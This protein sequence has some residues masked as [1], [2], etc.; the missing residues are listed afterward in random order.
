MAQFTALQAQ[1]DALKYNTSNFASSL[2]GKQLTIN[3]GA[4][5]P[6]APDGLAKGICTGVSMN[7][8]EVKVVVNGKEYLISSVRSIAEADKKDMAE[9]PTHETDL[10]EAT[11]LIGKEVTVKVVENGNDYYDSGIVDAVE[12]TDGIPQ[13]VIGGYVY[14]VDEVVQV[15]DPVVQTDENETL[16]Q[17]LDILAN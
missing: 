5:T 2:V 12:V 9:E 7:G 1:Q 4:L 17:I 11:A 8:K 15:K 6:D 14:Y 3:T 13:I 16:S 10:S